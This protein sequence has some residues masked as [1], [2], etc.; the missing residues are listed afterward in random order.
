MVINLVV[1]TCHLFS[2]ADWP[3]ILVLVLVLV[4]ILVIFLALLHELSARCVALATSCRL[5]CLGRDIS[6]FQ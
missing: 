2:V 1:E 4:L 6:V 3:C 5:R